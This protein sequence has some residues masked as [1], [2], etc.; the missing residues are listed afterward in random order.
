M[1]F[2]IRFW[3]ATKGNRDQQEVYQ[4]PPFASACREHQKEQYEVKLGA[5]QLD[6]Y[7]NDTVVRMVARVI[8]HSSYR[9]E[10]SQGDIALLQL[11]KP[12]IFSRYIRPICLPAANASFPNGLQCTVTGWGHVAP[13]GEMGHWVLRDRKGRLGTLSKQFVPTVSLQS[14][15]PLQQLEVPLISRE[16]CSC[17]YNINAV[18]EEPHTIQQDMLCAGYVRGGKDACQVRAQG[19]EYT[20]R[21]GWNR[22]G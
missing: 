21:A 20:L 14:P 2:G 11:S 22:K 9:E 5:H 19:T 13:S 8:T 10:G 3:D 4:A 1:L 15:R 7:S 6:S 16:T 18:P 12:V 17:L